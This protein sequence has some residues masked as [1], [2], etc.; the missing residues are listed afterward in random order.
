MSWVLA[1]LLAFCAAV[2]D[3]VM[4]VGEEGSDLHY[5]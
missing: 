5:A 3:G 2:G 4:W 1:D